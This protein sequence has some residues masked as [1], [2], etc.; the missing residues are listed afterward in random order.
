[1]TLKHISMS[2]KEYDR[3]S[4][5]V[6]RSYPKACILWIEENY[7]NVLTDKYNATKEEIQKKF[8]TVHEVECF[9]GTDF[10]SMNSIIKDGFN[11]SYNKRSA[12]GKGNYFAVASSYSKEYA[13]PAHDGISNMFICNIVYGSKVQGSLNI[14]LNPNIADCAVDNLKNPSIYVIPNNNAIYPKYVV[15]FYKNAV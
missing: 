9:H 5:L 10:H 13:I 1:M 4:D 7:N 14:G 8:G 2:C 6:K 12:Y 15:A 3:I 11:A